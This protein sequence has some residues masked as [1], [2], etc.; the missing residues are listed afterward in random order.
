M[1]KVFCAQEEFEARVAAKLEDMRARLEK[2]E[3]AVSELVQV[4][5]AELRKS[6]TELALE[7]HEKSA[8]ELVEKMGAFEGRFENVQLRQ[9]AEIKELRAQV[10]QLELRVLPGTG[11]AVDH[12]PLFAKLGYGA[13]TTVDAFKNDVA[14]KTVLN[15]AKKGLDADDARALAGILGSFGKSVDFQKIDLCGNTIGNVGMTAVAEIIRSG[16]FDGLEVLNIA[17]CGFGW[18]G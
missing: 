3:E 5:G 14:K 10:A 17:N 7:Q 4:M 18:K 6:L 2:G 1:S 12:T 8:T 9:Q 13:G 15:Y 11:L 16:A